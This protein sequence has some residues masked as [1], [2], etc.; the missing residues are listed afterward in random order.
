MY[1]ALNLRFH[2]ALCLSKRIYIAIPYLFIIAFNTFPELNRTYRRFTIITHI[3]NRFLFCYN[4][5]T[6]FR[7]PNYYRLESVTLLDGSIALIDIKSRANDRHFYLVGDTSKE[8]T[9]LNIEPILD[10]KGSTELDKI[11]EDIETFAQRIREKDNNL[12]LIRDIYYA[13]R[14]DWIRKSKRYL[15]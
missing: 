1:F 10:Y 7:N 3:G 2:F 12:A 5:Y 6:K 9:I 14:L 13:T 15:K 11:N 8:Y 4:Q